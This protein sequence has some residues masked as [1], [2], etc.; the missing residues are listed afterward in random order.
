MKD[1]DV[2]EA[3]AGLQDQ[4]SD[5]QKTVMDAIGFGLPMPATSWSYE[6]FCRDP[7]YHTDRMQKTVRTL[8]EQRRGMPLVGYIFGREI[9]PSGE[10]ADLIWYMIAHR[11][12]A[13][14][15]LA[16]TLMM[17]QCVKGMKAEAVAWASESW[18]VA[19]GDPVAVAAHLKEHPTLANYPGTS[20]TLMLHYETPNV[21]RA[22]GAKI[23]GT[24]ADR[25]LGPWR[26]LPGHSMGAALSNFFDTRAEA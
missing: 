26:E 23:T 11:V 17:K 10:K 4:L 12:D 14:I 18:E 21:Q 22:F 1:D 19:N 5:E 25:A 15:T 9:P 16:F 8:W 13:M 6:T 20:E 7:N 3:F 2:A 24:G